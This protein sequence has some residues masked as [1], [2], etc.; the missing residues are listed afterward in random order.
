MRSLALE[1]C[2]SVMDCGEFYVAVVNL[3]AHERKPE[4]DELRGRAK[5]RA[6]VRLLE[7][8]GEMAREDAG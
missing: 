7:R 5:D 3:S 4:D 2:V 8:I 1:D 6:R